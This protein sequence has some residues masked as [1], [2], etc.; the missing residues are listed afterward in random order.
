MAFPHREILREPRQKVIFIILK[1]GEPVC[2]LLLYL[3]CLRSA[4]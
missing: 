1:K 3:F 2:H 4:S